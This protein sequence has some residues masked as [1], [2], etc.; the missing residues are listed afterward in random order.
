MKAE[1]DTPGIAALRRNRMMRHLLDALARNEDIGHYGRLVFAMVAR[2][3]VQRDELVA[4]LRKDRSIDEGQA[5]SLVDQVERR[6]YSPPNRGRILAWQKQ[7]SFPL[8]PHIDDPDEA[9]VYRDLEFPPGVYE[10]IEA[11][12][13]QKATADDDAPDARANAS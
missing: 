3:F 4:W 5:L 7:Q 2:H 8:C 10:H 12:H 11:Y 1:Q 9:N 13:E 6:D